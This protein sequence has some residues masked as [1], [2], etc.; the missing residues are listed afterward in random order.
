MILVLKTGDPQEV[1]GY[2]WK[3]KVLEFGTRASP[4][5]HVLD[6]WFSAKT[7]RRV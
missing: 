7:I 5:T 1:V 6:M 4:K 2:I 3:R